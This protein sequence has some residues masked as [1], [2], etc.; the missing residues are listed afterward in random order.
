M[1]LYS[2]VKDIAVCLHIHLLP[3][4]KCGFAVCC[5]LYGIVAARCGTFLYFVLFIISVLC[6]MDHVGCFQYLVE[7]DGAGY[8]GF[9]WY[10]ACALSGMA[11]PL[12]KTSLFKYTEHFAT[13][14]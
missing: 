3:E 14:N 7:K 9:L 2:R 1:H 13:K 8:F 10:V 5:S 11:L 6:L 12:T 4:D